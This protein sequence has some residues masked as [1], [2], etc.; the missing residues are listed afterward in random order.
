MCVPNRGRVEGLTYRSNAI[1]R[2]IMPTTAAWYAK[3]TGPRQDRIRLICSSAARVHGRVFFITH[4]ILR[5]SARS[6]PVEES[7][8]GEVVF[9]FVY[10]F[11]PKD[12]PVATRHPSTGGELLFAKLK[13]RHPDAG[14]GPLR[15]VF[16]IIL[17]L[18]FQIMN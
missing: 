3:H 17:F 18:S 2:L 7:P 13:Y 4:E 1:C 6:P 10:F 15:H 11:F 14:Q 8:Q 5:T 12:H 16:F 9:C